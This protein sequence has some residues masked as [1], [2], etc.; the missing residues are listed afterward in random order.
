MQENMKETSVMVEMDNSRDLVMDP[1]I[2]HIKAQYE[3]ISV[4]SRK[5]AE[6]WYKTKVRKTNCS[7][8][9]F[10]LSNPV[11]T[12][13]T[14][15]LCRRQFDQMTVEA[16]QH[17]RELRSTKA[18]IS[19]LTRRIKKLQDEISTAKAQVRRGPTPPGF[20][21]ATPLSPAHAFRRSAATFRSSWMMPRLAGRRR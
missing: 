8:T 21:G 15:D 5:D 14:F 16:D 17:H 20:P 12:R 7:A 3:E 6:S 13:L 18:E 11:I 9:S 19:E 4:Q 10:L 1:I 2:A